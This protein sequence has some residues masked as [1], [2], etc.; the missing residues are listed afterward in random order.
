MS[1]ELNPSDLLIEQVLKSNTEVILLFIIILSAK[2]Y[3]LT[4]KYLCSCYFHHS[5]MEPA[6]FASWDA[7]KKSRHG[8]PLANS[9]HTRFIE[10]LE[11]V[12]K[13]Q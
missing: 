8:T 11:L 9:K 10:I 7:G 4:G 12:C 1:Q 6:K 13:I 5:A 2:L 3:L